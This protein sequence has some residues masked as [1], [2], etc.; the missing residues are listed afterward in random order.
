LHYSP[1]SFSSENR[2]FPRELEKTRGGDRSRTLEDVGKR[3]KKGKDVG[4]DAYLEH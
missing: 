2:R 3:K 1:E 4:L